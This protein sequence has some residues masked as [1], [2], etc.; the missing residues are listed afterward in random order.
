MTTETTGRAAM[1]FRSLGWEVTVPAGEY[2][3]G[4]PCYA[5]HDADWM[6]LLHSCGFFQ[7]KPVGTVRGHQVLG[8]GTRWGDGT[9]HDQDGHEYSVDAGLIGLVP[10]AL[11]RQAPKYDEAT[12]RDLGQIVAVGHPFTCSTDATS[13]LL[14]FGNTKIDTDPEV[15]D[16]YEG[17]A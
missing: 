3:L 6:P 1:E 14:I 12:L 2:F 11:W 5:V 17:G 4:D 10:L 15:E 7:D 8:F 16:D 13:G 9:Y